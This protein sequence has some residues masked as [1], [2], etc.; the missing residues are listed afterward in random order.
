MNSLRSIGLCLAVV[1]FISAVNTEKSWAGKKNKSKHSSHGKKGEK[2]KG[3]KGKAIGREGKIPPGIAKQGEEKI[4]KWQAA[5]D[6][7]KDRLADKVSDRAK[8]NKVDGTA[9]AAAVKDAVD[10]VADAGVKVERVE[11]ILGDAIDKGFGKEHVKGLAK[12]I[13][14]KIAK[15]GTP[16]DVADTASDALKTKV[17][18]ADVIK[19]VERSGKSTKSPWWKFWGK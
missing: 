13:A 12:V 15:G 2:E 4:A 18:A 3:G 6:K 19:A 7:S 14:D 1:L 8:K 5:K 16:A 17:S 9:E 10:V 11:D